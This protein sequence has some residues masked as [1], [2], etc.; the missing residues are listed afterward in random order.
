MNGAV[1]HRLLLTKSQVSEHTF[2]EKLNNFGQAAAVQRI[3]A[4]FISA[5]L[6]AEAYTCRAICH[7]QRRNTFDR[8]YAG[9]FAC[10]TSHSDAC[11]ADDA[12]ASGTA[13]ECT[14]AE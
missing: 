3:H 10:C 4:V 5:I 1:S 8:K 13:I 2:R 7:D 6:R 11:I 12:V 9:G 14:G